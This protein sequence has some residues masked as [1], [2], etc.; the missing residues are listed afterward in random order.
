MGAIY[1]KK[2]GKLIKCINRGTG[3]PYDDWRTEFVDKPGL[4]IVAKSEK[5]HPGTSFVYIFPYTDDLDQAYMNTSC[6][7]IE[8]SDDGCEITTERSISA[9]TSWLSR[10]FASMFLE[11]LPYK[12][13]HFSEKR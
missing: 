13:R 6:G 8:I 3:K 4:I 10:S 11:N 9:W 1:Q 5:K 2:F 12:R 7:N